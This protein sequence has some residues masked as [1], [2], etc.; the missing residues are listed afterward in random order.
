MKKIQRSLLK[1]LNGLK[2]EQVI[3]E[4]AKTMGFIMASLEFEGVREEENIRMAA[5]KI[6]TGYKY[7]RDWYKDDIQGGINEN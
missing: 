2:P 7:F 3:Q 5:E 6:A 1:T 4:L